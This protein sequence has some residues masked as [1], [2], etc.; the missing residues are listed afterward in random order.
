MSILDVEW[1]ACLQTGAVLGTAAVCGL[2]AH[3]LLFFFLKRSAKRTGSVVDDSLVA[4]ARRPARALLPLCAIL[5]ALPFLSLP[6]DL[7]EKVRHVVFLGMI[8]STA[9]LAIS[10]T[11][12]IDSFISVKFKIDVSDNLLARRVHTRTRVLR[13]ITVMTILVVAASMML[14]TF[15]GIRHVGVSLF[16][17]AGIIGV[18]AGIA[19][20]PV[21]SN[22]IAGIQIA[23]TEPIRIDDVVVIEGEY[24]LI[25]EIGTASVIVRLWDLR[26]LVVPLTHFI[27]RP[28]ENWTYKTAD[29]LGTVFLY[30]DYAV[31][32]EEVR[33]EL[34]RLLLSSG[35]WDGK[36]WA[37]EVT[38][39]SERAVELRALVSAR[40]SATS[41]KLRCHVREKLIG[42]LLERYPQGLPRVR[43]EIRGD[44]GM[45]RA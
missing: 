32:V 14:M 8:A 6:T 21:L 7:L 35:M 29:I 42:F 44:T 36:A 2:A 20:R 43:A 11:R 5:V 39:A 1:K 26:R 30:V 19:A 23:L 25:E 10:L 18:I 45:T 22:M 3:S 24:G 15:P 34:H 9:W 13:R 4:N 12:V 33:Q 31:P 27:E 37:L 38:N 17:S 16:A 41:W 28:F 40:D